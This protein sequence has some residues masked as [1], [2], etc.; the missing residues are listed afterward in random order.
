MDSI[1]LEE[2]EHSISVTLAPDPPSMS[3]AAMAVKE[4]TTSISRVHICTYTARLPSSVT[5]IPRVELMPMGPYLY[6]SLRRHQSAH[7]G[8]WTVI[9]KRDLDKGVW[10]KRKNTKVDEVGDLRGKVHIGLQDLGKL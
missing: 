7:S 2:L 1:F 3:N 10:E 9:M 4:N 8:L 5:W 6:P